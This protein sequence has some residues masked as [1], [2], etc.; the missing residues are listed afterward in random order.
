MRELDPTRARWR[1][2][3]CSSA[4]GQCVEVAQVCTHWRKSSYSGSNGACVEI[5][6][7]PEAVAVRDSKDPGGPKLI[8]TPHAWASFVES[9]KSGRFSAG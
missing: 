1:K 9:A 7:L 5:V 2:S 8:F 4:N 3:S 6:H